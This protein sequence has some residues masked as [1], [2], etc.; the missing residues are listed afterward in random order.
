LELYAKVLKQMD[1][2]IKSI[3]NKSMISMQESTAVAEMID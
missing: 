3:E 1:E 2:K